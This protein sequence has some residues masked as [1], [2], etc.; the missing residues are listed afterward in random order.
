VLG[1][2]VSSHGEDGII[3]VRHAP[4]GVATITAGYRAATAGKTAS[5]NTAR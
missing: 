2:T 4:D 1:G 3:L 5:I